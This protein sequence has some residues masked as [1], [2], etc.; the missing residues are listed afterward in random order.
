MESLNGSK[1]NMAESERAEDMALLTTN[2]TNQAVQRVGVI[3]L[4]YSVTLSFRTVISSGILFDR[5]KS[6]E[7]HDVIVL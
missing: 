3:M 5:L 1:S 6:C 7:Y 4:F 2:I